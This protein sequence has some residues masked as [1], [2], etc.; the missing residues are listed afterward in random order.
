VTSLSRSTGAKSDGTDDGEVDD[1]GEI[2]S[3]VGMP[4]DD[5]TSTNEADELPQV[6]GAAAA[7]ISTT[8]DDGHHRSTDGIDYDLDTERSETVNYNGIDDSLGNIT[9]T[10]WVASTR[11]LKPNKSSLSDIHACVT[12]LGNNTTTAIT[13]AGVNAIAVCSTDN[14]QTSFSAASETTTLTATVTGASFATGGRITND[15]VDGAEVVGASILSAEGTATG[16]GG[17]PIMTGRSTSA[18]PPPSTSSLQSSLLSL[19]GSLA[20]PKATPILVP[21]PLRLH[22]VLSD[23]RYHRVVT[24]VSSSR[25]SSSS[26]TISGQ[27]STGCS[28]SSSSSSKVSSSSSR[29]NSSSAIQA[30]KVVDLAAFISDVLPNKFKRECILRT[31]L[32]T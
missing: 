29:S 31:H 17:G 23:E 24:W 22:E 30:F 21:F 25:S 6:P 20:A 2:T 13:T 14:T 10:I 19:L 32:R 16:G 8:V 18:L 5:S 26:T 12:S 27:D 7:A 9:D 1:A 28:S 3:V 15:F 11:K 4:V